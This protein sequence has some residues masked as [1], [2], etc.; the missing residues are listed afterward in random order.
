MLIDRREN[1]IR[2][3]R[4]KK[5]PAAPHRGNANRPTRKRD[6]AITESGKKKPNRKRPHRKRALS[7][8]SIAAS[9]IRKL[10]RNRPHGER[11]D[12]HERRDRIEPNT[13]VMRRHIEPPD[14][15][16]RHESRE[17][18]HAIDTRNTRSRR[19]TREKRSRN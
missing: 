12:D 8:K 5:T 9:S 19:R 2:R 1:G 13:V 16:R 14:H 15:I 4:R 3:R 18:P 17:I 10:P 7:L 6:P 11:P